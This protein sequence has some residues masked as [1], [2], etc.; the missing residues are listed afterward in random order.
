MVSHFV[1]FSESGFYWDGGLKRMNAT[2]EDHSGFIYFG[3]TNTTL[4][5]AFNIS[6]NFIDNYDTVNYFQNDGVEIF[7]NGDLTNNDFGFCVE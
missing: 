7:I 2:Y 6:D 1:N 5:I 4:N 3:Y